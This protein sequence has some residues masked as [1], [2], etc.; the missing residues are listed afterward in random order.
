MS[1]EV[2]ICLCPHCEKGITHSQLRAAMRA[3]RGPKYQPKVA[4]AAATRNGR[5]RMWTAMRIGRRFTAQDVA[6]AA[7]APLRSTRKYIN[8]LIRVGYVRMVKATTGSVGD[9]SIYQLLKDTGPLAPR[10][11]NDGSVL[12]PN[13]GGDVPKAAA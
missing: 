3:Q 12:D 8:A 10:I 9:Y 5:T 1:A 4:T 2:H 6:A 13:L 7:E 11:H